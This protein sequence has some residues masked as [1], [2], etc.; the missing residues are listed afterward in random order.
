[1]AYSRRWR[2][3]STSRATL[4]SGRSLSLKPWR[5]RRRLRPQVP[6]PSNPRLCENRGLARLSH[7]QGSAPGPQVHQILLLVL[8]LV[9]RRCGHRAIVKALLFLPRP[10][11]RPVFNWQVLLYA[12][13]PARGQDRNCC[14]MNIVRASHTPADWLAQPACRKHNFDCAL[15]FLETKFC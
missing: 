8:L 12:C 10:F 15:H 6:I 7:L 2:A 13:V 3:G 5:S 9:R 11:S 14:T 4:K 1:M